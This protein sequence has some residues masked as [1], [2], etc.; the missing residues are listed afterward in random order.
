MPSINEALLAARKKRKNERDVARRKK[1]L[2]ESGAGFNV[3]RFG[4][5][6]KIMKV[7]KG[8]INPSEV[9]KSLASHGGES[10]AGASSEVFD[11]RI[12]CESFGSLPGIYTR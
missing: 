4:F 1:N 7:K 10:G 2:V 3:K 11:E 5:I 9:V 12:F 6:R 8:R